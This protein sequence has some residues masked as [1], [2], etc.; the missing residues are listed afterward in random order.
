[1]TNTSGANDALQRIDAAVTELSRRRGEIGSF[2]RN[3]LES[4]VRSLGIAK[5]LPHRNQQSMIRISP[6]K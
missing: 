2:M 5:T 3:V 1:M 4:N 6:K